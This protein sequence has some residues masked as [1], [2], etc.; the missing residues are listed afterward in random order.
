MLDLVRIGDKP[1]PGLLHLMPTPHGLPAALVQGPPLGFGRI[2]RKRRRGAAFSPILR[3]VC[4]YSASVWRL[5]LSAG[6]GG[7]DDAARA[8]P[9]RW[10]CASLAG[11]PI[12]RCPGRGGPHHSARPGDPHQP[13]SA[14]N[15]EPMTLSHGPGDKSIFA[16]ILRRTGAPP[17]VPTVH[18]KCDRAFI[19]QIISGP[20]QWR[21]L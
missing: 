1:V 19:F 14:P 6:D 13:C 3:A 20:L 15:S 5:S 11:C 16:F 9:S 7:A 8:T 17:N 21:Q 10:P 4:Q 12:W 18:G 2:D